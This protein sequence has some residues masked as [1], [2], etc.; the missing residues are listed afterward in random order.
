[1]KPESS[2]P[3]S[4]VPD[5]CPYQSISPGPRLSVWIFSN[6]ICFYG[7]ELLAPRPTPQA[8]GQPLAGCPRLLIQYI[9]SYPPH[10]GRSSIRNLRTRHAVVTG[11]HLQRAEGL[12][13][14]F[15]KR[16]IFVNLG[17]NITTVE[18]TSPDI[19]SPHMP[20]TRDLH[21]D[22]RLMVIAMC[23]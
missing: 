5:T 11:T 6:N 12:L 17:M 10:W 8:G 18:A 15:T 14:L 21:L 16:L 4:Q 13:Y 19:N 22:V 1:M 3:H 23:Q 2:L 7:E 20:V 9:R